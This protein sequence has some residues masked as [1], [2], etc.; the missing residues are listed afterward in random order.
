[1]D[2]LL[3]LGTGP[4]TPV[5][6]RFCTS[7]LLRTSRARVLI[8]AGEPCSQRLH[9]SSVPAAS[10]DAVLITH[11]HSDHTGGFPMLVQSAWLES[12]AKAL[13]VYLPQELTVPLQGWLDA[14]FLP[15]PLIGFPLVFHPWKA[16]RREEVADGVA[17][18]PF[19]T[20][21][22]HGLKKL[23]DSRAD[24]RFKVFG[25]ILETG[26]R[27]VVVSSDLGSPSDLEQALARP[28]DVLLCEL[29]HFSP[30]DL[31]AFLRNREIGHLVLT[32]L[33]PSLAAQ[34]E[35]VAAAARAT[36]PHIAKITVP[37]DGDEVLF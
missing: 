14:V 21:H 12:R 32:H 22:L 30:E 27:R 24:D 26:G 25:L 17:A 35:Q 7:V 10:L 9:E 4:G 8:D 11:G 31:F 33:A 1:M 6:G 36:L 13:P 2:S 20:T 3:F 16:G 15:A 37:R 5:R 28:C 19:P 18:T 29:A 23:I 34:E